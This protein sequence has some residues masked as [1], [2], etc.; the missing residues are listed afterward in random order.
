METE[1]LAVRV[2]LSRWASCGSSDVRRFR[3]DYLFIFLVLIEYLFFHID[4]SS[5]R[6]LP[7]LRLLKHSLQ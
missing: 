3:F 6:W 7:S 5:L 2:C 4:V 1:Q